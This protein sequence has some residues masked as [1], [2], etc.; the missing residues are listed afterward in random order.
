MLT[1]KW[2]ERMISGETYLI[3][4]CVVGCFDIW[5]KLVWWYKTWAQVVICLVM[6]WWYSWTYPNCILG[7]G[8]IIIHSTPPPPPLSFLIKKKKPLIEWPS[9]PKSAYHIEIHGCKQSLRFWKA[10]K[11]L[12]SLYNI[13]FSL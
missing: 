9:L 1:F 8:A 7:H 12:N 3:E 2:K 5:P 13:F 10:T 6:R 11:T 4:L